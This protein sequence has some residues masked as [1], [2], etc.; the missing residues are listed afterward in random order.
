M[1]KKPLNKK[2][3]TLH[4]SHKAFTLVELMA[5]VLILGIILAIVV[6][7]LFRQAQNS[8]SGSQIISDFQYIAQAIGDYASDYKQY[9]NQLS[10]LNPNN[11]YKYLPDVTI[12]GN[13]ATIDNLS[14]TYQP[15]D[16][17]NCN[18]G[19]SLYVDGLS[20]ET[21]NEVKSY[22]GSA[23]KWKLNDTNKTITLCL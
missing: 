3:K 2:E 7:K 9:P 16:N 23:I 5:V 6:P 22:I 10:D 14:F 12:T 21:Y 13:T 1:H 18:G 19:P 17:N 15:S 11:G 4:L 20:T 8:I